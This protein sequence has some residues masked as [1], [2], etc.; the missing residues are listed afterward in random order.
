[1][2]VIPWLSPDLTSANPTTHPVAAAG[3]R[4]IE[5]QKPVGVSTLLVTYKL[6]CCYGMC[7]CLACKLEQEGDMRLR[8]KSVH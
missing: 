8:D 4:W 2:L 3:T 1:M 5:Q 6:A 7:A